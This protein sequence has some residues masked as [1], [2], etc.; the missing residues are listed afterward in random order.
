MLNWLNRKLEAWNR[1]LEER[2][3]EKVRELRRGYAN[4]GHRWVQPSSKPSERPK[5]RSPGS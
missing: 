4:R 2:N 1:R 3:D 5:P